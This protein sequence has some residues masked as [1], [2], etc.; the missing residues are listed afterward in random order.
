MKAVVGDGTAVG[1]RRA[2]ARD[3][4]LRRARPPSRA[5]SSSPT[6]SS[7]SGSV[8]GRTLLIDEVLTPDSSRF[9]P[10]DRVRDRARAA[11][12]RQ[13]AAARLSG[14]RAQGR[15]LERRRA[16]AAPPRRGRSPRP[17]RATST[18]SAASPASPST[19]G[20][21]RELCP[22]RISVHAAGD[23]DRGRRL[24]RRARASQSGRSG[25]SPFVSRS[26]RS[27]SRTSSAIRS[28]PASA[29]TTWSS[30]PPTGAW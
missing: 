3:L 22:R 14:R 13:A 6:R 8:D 4:R 2:L 18:P 30:R 11:E 20:R 23:R 28:A 24:R 25:C 10:A 9:W 16:S 21:S 19:S 12:L 29:A 1:A 15:A 5:A 7:S 26:S 27:G 17:A